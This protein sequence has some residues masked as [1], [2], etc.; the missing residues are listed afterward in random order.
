MTANPFIELYEAPVETLTLGAYLLI[1]LAALVG[2][3]WLL[4]RNVLEL[5]KQAATETWAK[6]AP[7]YPPFKFIWR[8]AAIPVIV[9]IDLFLIAA[10]L[11]FAVP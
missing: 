11:Y 5:Y 8:L 1:L 7:L 9:A 6:N 10:F 2:T 3:W 4:T